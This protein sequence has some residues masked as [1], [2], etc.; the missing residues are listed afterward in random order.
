V[1]FW[2]DFLLFFC[3]LFSQKPFL[4]ISLR[5]KFFSGIF[6]LVNASEALPP[7]ENAFD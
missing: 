4:S 2:Q 3:G 7:F 1:I 5:V 6:W